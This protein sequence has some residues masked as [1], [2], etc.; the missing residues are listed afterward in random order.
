MEIRR[1]KG[2]K[3]VFDLLYGD[4]VIGSLDYPRRFR[5]QAY[6]RIGEKSWT[7][8]RPGVFRH[9]LLI[10]ADQSPY[11]KWDIDQGWS[12][13][14]QLRTDDNQAFLLKRKGWISCKWQWFNERME[15]LIDIRSKQFSFQKNGIVTI[16]QSPDERILW[17]IL[18]GWFVVMC[19]EDDSAAVA[20][21]S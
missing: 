5:K 3:R 10:A 13:T 11:G 21:I 7:L 15:N 9:R 20:I 4:R 19:Y 12:G 8:S 14:T 6:I 2:R 18:T 17:L 1:V 16:Y